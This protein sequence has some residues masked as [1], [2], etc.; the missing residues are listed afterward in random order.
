MGLKLEFMTLFFTDADPDVVI[1]CQRPRQSCPIG[2]ETT[3]DLYFELRRAAN[4]AHGNHRQRDADIY[5]T[6]SQGT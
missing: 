6:P 3:Y 5:G 1:I 2:R 4:G